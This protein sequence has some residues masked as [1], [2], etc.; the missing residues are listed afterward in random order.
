MI[1]KIADTAKKSISLI[2]SIL[3]DPFEKVNKTRLVCF[4]INF[5]LEQLNKLRTV[6][7]GSS[8]ISI[9]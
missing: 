8:K 4:E 2:L 6:E 9:L 7:S 5:F 3:T 1:I